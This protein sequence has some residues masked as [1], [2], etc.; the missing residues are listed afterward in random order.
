MY[1]F[2]DNEFEDNESP[3]RD[4]FTALKQMYCEVTGR[5]EAVVDK[6]LYRLAVRA[7]AVNTIALACV[8]GL[9]MCEKGKNKNMEANPG[10]N[11]VV[12]AHDNTKTNAILKAVQ[13]DKQ[14]K[15]N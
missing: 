14:L 7:L 10:T 8:T 12:V 9:L 2:D 13:N 3:I 6:R 5:K 1:N 4:S 15:K 11:T